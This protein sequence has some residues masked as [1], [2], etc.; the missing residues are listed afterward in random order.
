MMAAA[1]GWQELCR[2]DDLMLARAVTTSIA[3]M[4][5]DVCLSGGDDDDAQGVLANP[6]PSPYVV[7]VCP[8]DWHE[9]ASV[10]DE[11]VDEQED[12]DRRIAERWSASRRA[13]IVAV[14]ALG[15][16]GELVLQL[17]G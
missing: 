16:V 12:F 14:L 6:Q 2:F 13:R 8:S 11:I 17:V 7:L 5:F 1:N 10:L 3:A 9:I 4:E 15:G